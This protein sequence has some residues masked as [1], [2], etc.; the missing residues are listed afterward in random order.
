MPKRQM[1]VVDPSK[2]RTRALTAGDTVTMTGANAVLFERMGRAR[3]VEDTAVGAMAT[4]AATP[5]RRRRATSRK[6]AAK[7]TS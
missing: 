7:K 6:R 4:E 3:P 2:Y 5:T 1:I